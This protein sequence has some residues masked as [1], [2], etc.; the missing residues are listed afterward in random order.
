MCISTFWNRHQHTV[1]GRSVRHRGWFPRGGD[2]PHSLETQSAFSL[3]EHWP[4]QTDPEWNEEPVGVGW[5]GGEERE[6]ER[7]RVVVV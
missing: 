3:E 1:Q 7:E 6:R 2:H 5:G 4:C